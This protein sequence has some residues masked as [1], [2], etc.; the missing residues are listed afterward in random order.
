MAEYILKH[1]KCNFCGKLIFDR[2]DTYVRKNLEGT[3]LVF[4]SQECDQDYSRRVLAKE[5]R[6]N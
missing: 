5:A 1:I 6:K 2:Y 3:E 4:C